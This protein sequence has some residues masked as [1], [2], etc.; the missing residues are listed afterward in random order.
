MRDIREITILKNKT[1]NIRLG[2]KQIA[3]A[4]PNLATLGFFIYANLF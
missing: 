2:Q 1:K 4:D 3:L